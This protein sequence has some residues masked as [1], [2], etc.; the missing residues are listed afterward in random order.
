MT[1]QYFPTLDQYLPDPKGAFH[2]PF[3]R[4]SIMIYGSNAGVAKGKKWQKYPALQLPE[5]TDPSD[6]R[7]QF[8]YSGGALLPSKKSVSVGDICRIAMMYEVNPETTAEACSLQRWSL[9][10]LVQV[11]TQPPTVVQQAPENQQEGMEG[12]TDVAGGGNGGGDGDEGG[13]KSEG[14]GGDGGGNEDGD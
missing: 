6:W 14:D 2:G 9:E 5:R 8:V 7:T 11:G 1:K 12:E 13:N 10:G 3:D 4:F